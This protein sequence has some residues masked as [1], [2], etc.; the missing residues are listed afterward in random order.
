V[1]S[2]WNRQALFVVFVGACESTPPSPC[3][4]AGRTERLWELQEVVE[5]F[6]GRE[7]RRD[8]AY[9]EFE[10]APD[11]RWLDLDIRLRDGRISGDSSNNTGFRCHSKVEA[12]VWSAALEIPWAL[13]SPS[14][15]S[16]ETWECNFY[17][18]APEQLGGY[19]MAWSPTGYGPQC[20]HRPERFGR[21][22]LCE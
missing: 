10:V 16:P 5:C 17:R 8:N 2:L 4:T 14:G 18:A 12:G 15:D 6:I 21:L 13:L 11:G 3:G 19:L 20:F 9:W 22:I 7:A 1:L